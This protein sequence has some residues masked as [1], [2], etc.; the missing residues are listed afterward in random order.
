MGSVTECVEVLAEDADVP[1]RGCPG[2]VAGRAM[3][4]LAVML[5]LH[6]LGYALPPSWFGKRQCTVE[7][8][9]GPVYF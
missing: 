2:P 3:T 8:L 9:G 6:L 4:S 7:L 5:V 1:D